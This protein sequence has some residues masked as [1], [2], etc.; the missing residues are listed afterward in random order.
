[1]QGPAQAAEAVVLNELPARTLLAAQRAGLRHTGVM[2]PA[3]LLS[4]S[5]RMTRHQKLY[6]G[7][8]SASPSV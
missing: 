3:H 8:L 7:N 2:A 6:S 1:M 5:G 4:V